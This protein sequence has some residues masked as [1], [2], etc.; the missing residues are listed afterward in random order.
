MEDGY[1]N[2]III[3]SQISN[4]F[5][6]TL[7]CMYFWSVIFML[8]NA[9]KNL[10]FSLAKVHHITKRSLYFQGLQHCVHISGEPCEKQAYTF[11]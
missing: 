8:R 4:L 6:R 1:K 9:S 2:F 11:I 5:R 7:L 10:Y 3:A